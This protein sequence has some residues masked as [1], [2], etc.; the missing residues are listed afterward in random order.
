MGA[1]KPDDGYGPSV[2]V[3]SIGCILAE[4]LYT[5]PIFPGNTEIEQ[6]SLIFDLCG[7][8]TTE[9]WPAVMNL[10]LW[11]TFAPKDNTED[12]A[13]DQPERKPR[14]L[15]A[16]FSA[17]EETALDLIDEILVHNP[18]KRIS[19]HDALE[20]TYL[21]NAKR[22]GDLQPLAVDSAHEWEVRTSRRN[23]LVHSPA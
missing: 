18:L 11:E 19:A 21:K 15:R 16:T 14:R 22:P 6:L 2:D 3:W 8:P 4:L 5:K 10:P 23:C 9:D 13:D 1:T 17:F 12:S 7:T 20:G